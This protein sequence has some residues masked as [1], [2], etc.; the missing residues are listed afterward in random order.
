MREGV[1][2][3]TTPETIRD[4]DD[5]C[6]DDCLHCE[7][8]TTEVQRPEEAAMLKG[9]REAMAGTG[10]KIWSCSVCGAW[11]SWTPEEPA[12]TGCPDERNAGMHNWRVGN[13]SPFIPSDP[14]PLA[15]LGPR[16]LE[17]FEKDYR[18]SAHRRTRTS[19]KD[20]AAGWVTAMEKHGG[21]IW[22]TLNRQ[23]T[24]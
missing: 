21:V 9:Y 20:F 12:A 13:K 18:A 24:G 10:N 2:V 11:Q 4:H 22:R 1:T 23:V 5:H 3:T 8:S 15:G 7:G 16:A 6:T 19:K 14:D 17:E